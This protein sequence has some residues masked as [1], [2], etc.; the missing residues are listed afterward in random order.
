MSAMCDRKL[1]DIER[2]LEEAKIKTTWL[3]PVTQII[4]FADE[5]P[6]YKCLEL[7]KDLLETLES[8]QSLVIRGDKNDNAVLCTSSKT[9]DLKDTETSNS[10]LIMQSLTYHKDIKHLQGDDIDRTVEIKIVDKL[11]HNYLE[12]RLIQPHL[13]IIQELLS[14]RL[15]KG[16]ERESEDYTEDLYSLDKLLTTVQ[17]S[18]EEILNELFALNAIEYKGYWRLLEFEYHFRI[19]SFI[20]TYIEQESVPFDEIDKEAC[21]AAHAEIVPKEIFEQVFKYY[22]DL[23]YEKPGLGYYILKKDK[24][25]RMVAESILKAARKFN[26]N[27]FLPVWQE[28]VIPGL[29][30]N[31]NQL[32]GIVIIA[33]DS[34][35]PA[36]WYFPERDLPEDVNLRLQR[37]FQ[38]RSSWPMDDIVPYMQRLATA[39]LPVNA[40]LAKYARMS[41][42]E[43]IKYFTGRHAK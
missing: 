21:C 30:T 41:T 42:K 28:S 40:L 17:A 33:K 19:F 11:V 16:P 31:L 20:T 43:G 5:E 34:S 27:E 1:D 6:E 12:P 38:E 29:E 13:K 8:G 36:I 3:N 22:T 39:Q 9:Y 2:T 10:L 32:T 14:K 23:N 24:V 18:E 26:L 15:F 37:L 35:P 25:C 7:N 4:R